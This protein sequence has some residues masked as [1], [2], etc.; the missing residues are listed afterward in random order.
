M[1]SMM[2]AVKKIFSCQL[3][4][5]AQYLQENYHKASPESNFAHYV[6]YKTNSKPPFDTANDIE[7]ANIDRNRLSE[8]PTLAAIG[9]GLACG[10]QFS[11]DFLE[12]WANGL[13]R[14]SGREAFPTHRSSF[15]YRPTEL[16][17]IALGICHY[18]KSQLEQSKWL[19]E[20]LVQGETRLIHSDLWTFLL[21]AYAAHTL[22]VTWKPRSLPLVH[23]MTVDELALVK[24]LCS[25]ESTFACKFG[26][27][28]IEP[29]VDKALLE[30]CIEFSNSTRD[31]AHTVLLYFALKRTITQVLQSS[32]D[33]FEKIRCNPQKAIEWLKATCDNIHTV[34]QHL[35]FQFTK[36][37]GS[38]TPNVRT[39]QMLLQ[40]LSRLRDDTNAMEV[41]ITEQIRVHSSLYISN[42]QGT[43]IT[44][45]HITIANQIG[46]NIT[47]YNQVERTEG[48]TSLAKTILILASNP[49]T[50][51]S[52]R[53][54]EEVREIEEGLQRAKKRDQFYLKQRWAVRVRDVYQ[55]LLD[56]QPQ[57][58]HF[59]A[60]G[61]GDSGLV[62]EDE[63]GNVQ[64]VETVA[65][66]G[67][68]ELFA[69]HIECVILSACYSEVQ[70]TAISKHIPYVIGMKSEIGDK[71]AIKFATGFYNALG[72]G[73]SVEFAYKL[74]CSV[75]QLDG[76][77]EH[78]TPVLKKK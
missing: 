78:L 16:L 53:L 58:V 9:Y 20:I 48:D 12:V 33:D 34:A 72:S 55:S 65:L 13:V 19:Q 41:Q 31:S 54:D 32:W 59:S 42:N 27:I 24:W 37:F 46:E 28:K 47:N 74:G 44:G 52:L 7:F 21:S 64:L 40:A 45:S 11:Q 62:L 76:I 15:F 66:A 30:Y 8:G 51:S 14:L 38:E 77:V 39:M 67:L 50:T 49:K 43:V 18:Y 25:I 60:H 71:A 26:L 1:V 5:I 17:G 36:E 22:S 56:F 29:S 6:F 75:I 63:T 2:N 23:E 4:N 61:T 35:Q 68:F 69:P 73:E 57:I 70:A 10:R 3:D